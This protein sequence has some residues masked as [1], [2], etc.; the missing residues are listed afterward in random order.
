MNR[1]PT[2]DI[3]GIKVPKLLI[4]INSLL[5]WSHTSV[6]RDRW[7]RR[8]YTA[9]RVAKVFERCIELGVYGVLGPVWPRLI[10]AIKIAEKETGQQMTFISTTIGDP[11]DTEK[12]LKMLNGL[13]SPI[14]CIHGAWTDSWPIKNS[15]L[16]GFEKYLQMIREAGL[17]PGVACHNG[18]RLSMVDDGKYDVSV[19]V[20]PVNKLGFYMSPTQRSILDAISRTPKPVIAIK[21]LAGGRF[22]EGRIPEW[23]EWVLSQEGVSA[24]CIGFMSREEAE[25]DIAYMKDLLGVS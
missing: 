11:K 16:V 18:D 23:L 4:G 8:Y 2:V 25:E 14:C 17:I 22:Q 15:R 9:R 13:Y 12:Q 21:P 24:V 6:G 3:E 20:T 10:K 19:F 5:G 7:I 1:F